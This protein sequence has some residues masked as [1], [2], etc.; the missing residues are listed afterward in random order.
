M[1]S[2]MQSPTTLEWTWDSVYDKPNRRIDQVTQKTTKYKKVVVIADVDTDLRACSGLLK[3][4]GYKVYDDAEVLRRKHE[5]FW[6]EA[7]DCKQ[8][9]KPYEQSDW[10]KLLGKYDALVSP[11]I[12]PFLE[13][14]I[15]PTNHANYQVKVIVLRDF[16]EEESTNKDST[17]YKSLSDYIRSFLTNWLFP[18]MDPKG[19]GALQQF[20]ELGEHLQLK[21]ISSI[22]TGRH[23]K[24]VKVFSLD[25]DTICNILEVAAP[26]DPIIVAGSAEAVR[27]TSIQDYIGM[28]YFHSVSVCFMALAFLIAI[29]KIICIDSTVGTL[30]I[31]I[32]I[33]IIAGVLSYFKLTHGAAL[34]PNQADAPTPAPEP[35]A[36]IPEV[37][38][39][40]IE[41]TN[42][43]NTAK[44][45]NAAELAAAPAE[46]KSPTAPSSQ[47]KN[48]ND[49][50]RKSDPASASQGPKARPV[51]SGWGGD[52]YATIKAADVAAKKARDEKA[53]ADKDKPLGVWTTKYIPRGA[54]KDEVSK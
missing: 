14:I 16:K 3:Q 17:A 42:A 47:S 27:F 1:Q 48:N 52:I 20:K 18:R 8:E 36:R 9:G 37:I 49:S 50:Q 7:A 51:L 54:A 31:I 12:I 15:N 23:Q 43:A 32:I 19:L 22:V 46:K 6:T 21:H 25:K 13:E 24:L 53:E 44:A 34:E 30:I 38:R 10:N 4:L 29:A 2:P 11:V 33:I 28:K 45:A 40:Q 41:R 35:K 26:P 39:K 5:S